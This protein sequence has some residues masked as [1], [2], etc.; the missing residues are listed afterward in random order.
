M[1]DIL[2]VT[3]DWRSWPA[4]VR[5]AAALAARVGGTLT[6]LCAVPTLTQIFDVS[7]PSLLSELI[8]IAQEQAAAAYRAEAPFKAWAKDLGIHQS[9]WYV[10]KSS[11]DDALHQAVDWHDL[12]VLGR[13]IETPWQSV[14]DVGRLLLTVRLPFILIPPDSDGSVRLDTIAIA[15]NGSAECLRALHAALPLLRHAK[16]IVLIRNKSRDLVASSDWGATVQIDAYLGWH[17]LSAPLSTIEVDDDDGK[18]AVLAAAV[19][20]SADMLVMGAYG[21]PRFNE[22]LFGGATRHALEYARMPLFMRH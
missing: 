4:N 7:S 19:Q 17:G 18:Y 10:T 13:E 1:H 20:T 16:K 11:I 15:W 21:R 3:D 14:N 5:Y 2:A 12:L 9:A 22:W 8:E 6:G